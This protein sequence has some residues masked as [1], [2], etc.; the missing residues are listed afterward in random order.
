MASAFHELRRYAGLD[1]RLAVTGGND[2]GRQ[3]P[4]EHEASDPHVHEVE[5]GLGASAGMHSRGRPLRGDNG[6]PPERALRNSTDP[7]STI[8]PTIHRIV[9]AEG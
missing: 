1:S 3:A 6:G 2:L 7:D 9:R 5:S 4:L 8:L